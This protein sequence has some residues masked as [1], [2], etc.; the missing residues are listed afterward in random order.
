MVDTTSVLALAGVLLAG[1][2]AGGLNVSQSRRDAWLKAWVGERLLASE[3]ADALSAVRV[4]KTAD[5]LGRLLPLTTSCWEANREAIA[6][7]VDQ[8]L[9]LDL[10]RAYADIRLLNRQWDAF[11]PP[12]DGG[13]KKLT[14]EQKTELESARKTAEDHIDP[15]HSGLV[16]LSVKASKPSVKAK[17]W[18]F[19]IGALWV[20]AS[21][22]AAL[23]IAVI[24]VNVY[25]AEIWRSAPVVATEDDVAWS[26]EQYFSGEIAACENLGSVHRKFRCTVTS[27]SPN[28]TYAQPAGH[29]LCACNTEVLA[30]ITEASKTDELIARVMMT[31]SEITHP[32][33][34]PDE[35]VFVV[36]L[37]KKLTKRALRL[38]MPDDRHTMIALG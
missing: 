37:F 16:S 9:W 14:D 8:A 35:R 7:Y 5:E 29:S 15:A 20:L 36:P 27:R 12:E 26:L 17:P 38:S 21:L 33:V 19:A 24:G 10:D 25:H 4:S 6:P 23:G 1:L 13:A 22:L 11:K 32:V 34:A 31:R 30:N 3:L 18:R 2:V 28:T